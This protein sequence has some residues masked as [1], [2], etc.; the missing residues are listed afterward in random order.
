MK[1]KKTAPAKKKKKSTPKPEKLFHGESGVFPLPVH[2][3]LDEK[4]YPLDI[5]YNCIDNNADN[6]HAVRVDI[7]KLS[8]CVALMMIGVGLL[9]YAVFYRVDSLYWEKFGDGG[10]DTE[11]TSKE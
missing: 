4:E 8:I 7:A 11:E 2:K 6:I 10:E 9:V 5:L 1:K 3:Y